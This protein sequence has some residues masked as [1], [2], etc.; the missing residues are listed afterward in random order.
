MGDLAANALIRLRDRMKRQDITPHGMRSTF[1]DWSM[2]Q[3]NFPYHASE[4]ALGHI[5]GDEVD[6]A[7]R[8]GD[9]LEIRFKLA[10]G[11]GAPLFSLSVGQS[12]PTG[13]TNA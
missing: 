10:R 4:L 2:E 8:R 9:M 11:L 3:T 7:Y 13:T 1:K 5:V 6:R 12:G